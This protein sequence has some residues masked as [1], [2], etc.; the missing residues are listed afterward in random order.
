M[1]SKQEFDFV[2]RIISGKYRS[3]PNYRIFP[4]TGLI[5][6]GE[7]GA[8]ITAEKKTKTQKNGNTHEYT[9]YHCT[10]QVKKDCSQKSIRKETLNQEL[11]ELLGSIEIPEE[12]HQWA[13]KTLK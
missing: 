12:F 8:M 13:I 5:R 3:T 1:V 7:R 4:F 10:K 2:Q 6:C 9:Y 11:S